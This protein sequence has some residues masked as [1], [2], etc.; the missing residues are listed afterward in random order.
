ASIAGCDIDSPL[1]R[2]VDQPLPHGGLRECT[3]DTG[4]R[5]SP[6]GALAGGSVRKW[7][8]RTVGGRIQRPRF[9]G[10]DGN[11]G[12]RSREML[13]IKLRPGRTSVHGLD[14]AAYTNG[15]NGIA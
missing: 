12:H 8:R 11:R 14:D 9:G 5:Q 6:V 13:W 15:M 10:V 1:R 4:P 7:Y 3:A 2:W